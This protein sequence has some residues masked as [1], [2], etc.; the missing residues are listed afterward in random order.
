[1][2]IENMRSATEDSFIE[3]LK[4]EIDSNLTNAQFGV[5][6]LAKKI[7]MSRSQLHRKLSVISGQ[8]VSQFIREYRLQLAMDLLK[9]G[10]LT[11]TE[12]ADKTGFGSATYFNKC[13]N[14]YYGFPPGEVIHVILCG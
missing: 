6:E 7:G 12:V 5:E 8:S 2:S 13:F 9:E 3:K 14:D 10:E 1:M 4:Q 11:A